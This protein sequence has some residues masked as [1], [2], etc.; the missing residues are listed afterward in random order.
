[1]VEMKAGPQ[2]RFHL[3]V[4]KRDNTWLATLTEEVSGLCISQEVP[5]WDS[6]SMEE[7]VNRCHDF[8]NQLVERFMAENPR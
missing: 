4:D 1:M 3:R 8:I 2:G 7:A 5:P 6:A